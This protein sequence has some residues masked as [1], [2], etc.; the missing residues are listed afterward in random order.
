MAN[1]VKTLDRALK[2]QN[3]E[4]IATTMDSFEK[5]FENLDVRTEFMETAMSNTTSY[6]DRSFPTTM[7]CVT[8]TF[9]CIY[10]CSR[11]FNLISLF[12]FSNSCLKMI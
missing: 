2:A 12:C 8:C 11:A 9:L 4:Q 10:F 5:Q 1:I 6:K 7:S 3:L